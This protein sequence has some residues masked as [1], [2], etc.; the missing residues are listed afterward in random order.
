MMSVTHR[1]ETIRALLVF[2]RASYTNKQIILDGC[3]NV[4]KALSE[5]EN[6]ASHPI[7]T[8]ETGLSFSD[9][10]EVLVA[11]VNADAASSGTRDRPDTRRSTWSA[12]L[13]AFTAMWSSAAQ[14]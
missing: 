3:S 2:I 14:D 7:T 11:T 10:M 5:S 1:G 13:Q 12:R 9:V 4:E 8:G 6:L